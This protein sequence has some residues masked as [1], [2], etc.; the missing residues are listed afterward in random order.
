MPIGAEDYIDQLLVQKYAQE[1]V[2]N[3]DGIK[4]MVE[5]EKMMEAMTDYANM[6][7][8]MFA[9]SQKLKAACY[10][11]NAIS[12]QYRKAPTLS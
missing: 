10:S 5:P 6:S 12:A 7:R 2:D 11:I 3:H 8:N 4:S 1:K 9:L